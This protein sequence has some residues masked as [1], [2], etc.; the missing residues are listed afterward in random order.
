MD[1][2]GIQN[3]NSFY[4]AHYLAAVLENDLKD[5]LKDWRARDKDATAALPPPRL[6]ARFAPAYFRQLSALRLER[7]PAALCR[8]QREG[9][10]A[11]LQIAGYTLSPGRR[12]LDKNLDLPIL[13]EVCDAQ[14]APLLWLLEALPDP[15]PNSP[16][17]ER[18]AFNVLEAS[19]HPVQYADS[20]LGATAAATHTNTDTNTETVPDTVP[21]PLRNRSWEA[22]ISRE[23]FS[24]PEP[25]R[26]VLL[27]ALHETVLIDRYKWHEKKLLR[28]DWPELLGR[29]DKSTLEAALALLHRDQL[30]PP[31]QQ[32]PPLLDQLSENAHK[33]AHGV[34]GDLKRALRECI[35]LLG[36]EALHYFRHRAK[37]RL[38]NLDAAEIQRVY[39]IALPEG[40][41]LADQLTREALRYMYR[42]LF[43]FYI[44]ARP[45]LGYAPINTSQT[46][47]RGYSLES[48]RELES[49]TLTSEAARNGTYFNET[50]RLLFKMVYAGMDLGGV[51]QAQA[52]VNKLE[53]ALEADEQLLDDFYAF[54]LTGLDAHLFDPERTPLL[55]RVVFRNQVLQQVIQLMSLTAASGRQRRGRISYAQLGISQLGQV[56]E[57]LLSYRG[58]FAE[59]DLYEVKPAEVSAVD[60]LDQGFFVP[61]R[62]LGHYSAA[63]KVFDS[64]GNLVK[65]PKGRFIYRLAG[66][67]RQ[68]S[69]SYY[70]PD[71]LTRCLVKYSLQ[72]LLK[73]QPADAILQLKI[74]EPAMGSAAF[75]NEAVNQL[76]EAYLSRKQQELGQSIPHDQMLDALQRVKMYLADNAVHGVDLNP[77]A[78]ELAEVSLWLNTICRSEQGR[79]FVPWFG[80]QLLT[81]NSL[82]GARREIYTPA[83]LAL[84]NF[85]SQAPLP[86]P[87]KASASSARLADGI[88]HF[89]LPDPGMASFKD[90]SIQDLA[91][92]QLA[93]AE[94][95]RK[96][97]NAPLSADEISRLQELS[98]AIDALW[99]QVARE[100][101][102][103][104]RETT[105]SLPIFGQPAPDRPPSS[106]RD[107]DRRMAQEYFSH[108]VR[109]ASA[110]RRLKL[111]LDYWCALWFWP[112]SAADSLPERWAFIDDLTWIVD[113]NLFASSPTTAALPLF[114][115]TLPEAERARYQNE[116]GI[117]DLGQLVADNPRLQ[118]VVALAECYRFLHWEL[119]FADIFAERGGFDFVLGNPPWIKVEWEEKGILSDAEPR[120]AIQKFSASRLASLRHETLAANAQLLSAYLEAYESV[121]ATQNFLKAAQNYPLL[122]GMKANL[123]KCF[124]PLAWRIADDQGVSA[125]VHPEG[126]YDDPSGGA[127]REA[128]YPRLRYHFQFQNELSLFDD[129][130]HHMK[131][132]IN[133][134]HGQKTETF[135]HLGNLYTTQT[136]EQC[137]QHHGLGP[138]S[139]IK[140]D[141]NKWNTQAHRDRIIEVDQTMLQL[142]ARLYDAEGTPPLQA[143]LPVVHSRQ[144]V[145]VLKKFADQPRRLGDFEGEYYVT[146]Y[147]NET[148]A[149][150]DG[151][152]RR[153]TQFPATPDQWILSG[154]HFYVGTPLNKTPR[155]E[156]TANMHYDT[157]DLLTL[158]D[159]YLPRTNYVPACSPEAYA[160]RTPT[161]PW[162]DQQPVT[163]YYRLACRRQLSQSGE[164]TLITMIAPPQVAHI[165]GVFSLTFQSLET[166]LS[167]FSLTL[168]VPYDFL[169]KSTGKSDFRNDTA[170]QLILT[171]TSAV[172]SL[173]HM[174]VLAL[175]CLTTHYA[176]LWR[177]C[178]DPAYT[179]QR[180]AKADPRLDN[181]FFEALTPHWQRHCA[182]RSDYAR[183]QALVEI[184]VLA[185]MALGLS[186]D[187]L[188]TIYRIQFPV[189]RQYEQDT[190]Y[191]VR[192]RIVFTAS[193]G[194]PGVG[195]P[196]K[197]SAKDLSA[198][199]RYSIDAPG[200]QQH[201]I[202]LGW[203]DVQH[204]T[205]GT[206][207]KTFPDDTLPGGPT[208]R[209]I[210]YHAPFDR[211]DRET[212]YATTWAYFERGI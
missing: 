77:V 123:Y 146:Q 93:Q 11:L 81:G 96:A 46:Y 119:A 205:Q 176:D 178:W 194:L 198:G 44:E 26:F 177:E 212:D 164:R 31:E 130:D 16:P 135:W 207:T 121:A 99:Q 153:D 74:C 5:A 202:A 188:Q 89:L 22:L 111:V 90:K 45:E 204:L 85:S 59:E 193:K 120:F 50:L 32:G 186:L 187:E 190:W 78:V 173:L 179:Q 13:G 6:L 209:S 154:P 73:D 87:L 95:W 118:Q 36:N 21:E 12:A 19:L 38:F 112:L 100:Q 60:M 30:C 206:I 109:N 27:C 101:A 157:L 52:G 192:G 15:D 155:R 147:W 181:G 132:S 160:A 70:T 113:S 140:D 62:D 54:R 103:L 133:I 156:C 75:L 145:E 53:L 191:D 47:L 83:Q 168:S 37:T 92:E 161:V 115:E 137:F 7:Q 144:V 86:V 166:M 29:S 189:M 63:E 105:D 174:R 8:L 151:T 201:D 131:F 76:A 171:D 197:A 165:D 80:F 35:E 169:V 98:Q 125:F 110:Y 124:L 97:F 150:N 65:H 126:V 55:N 128:L 18:F 34:T 68:T 170:K 4:P 106:T 127:L 122:K 88:W 117:V 199:I 200:R 24:L 64:E 183:R 134:F 58:F 141:D 9:L 195:L 66:R 48:L 116:L 94:S 20:A 23:V 142:F 69:A 82:I 136:V 149:Q 203:E 28:F 14:G 102:R 172:Q 79:A 210:T 152:M 61:A 40:L 180:W 1:L 71:L 159:D 10:Y 3:E 33:N 49:V 108:D 67:D 43:L 185:A 175:N 2:T 208:E 42:L 114:A 104:R 25:P 184:D 162:G 182:L 41:S 143:R 129:V 91:P 39:N 211:C 167:V 138:V 57:A 72:T 163:A 196:R 107:K 17:D 84:K 139:G 158:P 56:Y 148:N 51:G